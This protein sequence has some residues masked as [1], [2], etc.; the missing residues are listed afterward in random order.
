M[1]CIAVLLPLKGALAQF[2]IALGKSGERRATFDP[3]LSN[4]VIGSYNLLAGYRIQI[5]KLKLHAFPLLAT[6]PGV[7]TASGFCHNR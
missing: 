3:E 4:D 7:S 6:P 5:E 1:V 2:I